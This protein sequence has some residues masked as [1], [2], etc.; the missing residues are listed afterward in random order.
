MKEVILREAGIIHVKGTHT[1]GTAKPVVC[2]TT[3][4]KFASCTDAAEAAGVNIW[5]ISNCCRGKQ[6]Y[7]N[8]HD[9]RREYK[10]AKEATEKCIDALA[11]NLQKKLEL[12]EKYRDLIEEKEVEERILEAEAKRQEEERIAREK[13]QKELDRLKKRLAHRE[14][15]YQR[16]SSKVSRAWGAVAQ[17]KSEIRK[18]ECELYN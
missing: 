5:A 12:L 11:D 7:V 14:E 6:K 10:F 17:T 9:G 8:A 15:M 4:E 2:I 1:H 13:R 16:A 3:G 18:L